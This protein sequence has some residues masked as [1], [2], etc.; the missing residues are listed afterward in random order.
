MVQTIFELGGCSQ[1]S[2][3]HMFWYS[4]S[5]IDMAKNEIPY[6][7]DSFDEITLGTF[8][9]LELKQKSYSNIP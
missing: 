7:R 6:H 8:Y 4:I 5:R 1:C 3:I 2:I 9:V